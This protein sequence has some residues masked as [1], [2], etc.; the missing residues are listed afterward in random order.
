MN[1]KG[2]AIKIILV[3]VI[4]SLLV[5]ASPMQESKVDLN[6]LLYQAIEAV[7]KLAVAAIG[8]Y[9]AYLLN[10][11]Q[12]QVKVKIGEKQYEW[13]KDFIRQSVNAVAQNPAIAGIVTAEGLQ[14]Y[15][16]QQATDF[17]IQKNLPFTEVQIINLVEAAVKMLK[18]STGY[19][20]AKVLEAK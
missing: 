6:G 1:N 7:L 2:K 8:V 12:S 3:V 15:V 16:I 10:T 20:A 14:K 11:L 5:A 19:S 18:E 4:A 9:G 13:L 17:C